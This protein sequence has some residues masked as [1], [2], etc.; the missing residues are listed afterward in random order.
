MND[1]DGALQL[2]EKVM[3]G[4]DSQLKDEARKLIENLN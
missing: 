3:Q 1:V 4:D 2:L